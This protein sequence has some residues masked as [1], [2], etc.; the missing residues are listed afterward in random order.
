MVQVNTIGHTNNSSYDYANVYSI[1]GRKAMEQRELRQVVMFVKGLLTNLSSLARTGFRK[2]G[3]SKPE[4]VLE[5]S[6]SVALFAFVIAIME[7]VN[8]D[9]SASM[10]FLHDL[11][12]SRTGDF[13]PEA[14]EVL[15]ALGISKQ[16]MDEAS[17]AMQLD[18]LPLILRRALKK[19]MDEFHRQETVRAWCVHDADL[20][21]RGLKALLYLG[22]AQ[23]PRRLIAIINEIESQLKTEGGRTLWRIMLENEHTKRGD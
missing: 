10:G 16:Q 3:I 9:I 21:D 23:F 13:D 18:S 4:T 20:L 1:W 8:P 2:A 11:G 15:K 14:T 5:H 17:V 19:R 22:V 6:F 12:E 7:R